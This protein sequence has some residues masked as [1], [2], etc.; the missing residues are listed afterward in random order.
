MNTA[1]WNICEWVARLSVATPVW[2]KEEW[3]RCEEELFR[4]ETSGYFLTNGDSR[5]FRFI[6][7]YVSTSS[8]YGSWSSGSQ[9][10][11]TSLCRYIHLLSEFYFRS[12]FH[13]RF[14]VHTSTSPRS[15]PGYHGG[16]RSCTRT[17]HGGCRIGFPGRWDGTQLA[18]QTTL[19]FGSESIFTTGN[20]VKLL[21]DLGKIEKTTE[22][23]MWLSTTTASQKQR[24][25]YM[26]NVGILIWLWEIYRLSLENVVC[27]LRYLLWTINA[28][29]IV[30]MTFSR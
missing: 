12:E 22:A 17:G 13:F 7:G 14:N 27:K 16:G 2:G 26:K 11:L 29:K 8:I 3:D 18:G 28:Q 4:W 19:W 20:F 10:S 9:T 30:K 5:Y 15:W 23:R 1:L 24:D 6:N 21:I 25:F